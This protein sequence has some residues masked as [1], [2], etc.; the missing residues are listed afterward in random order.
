M[1][2]WRSWFALVFAGVAV[3][4]ACSG[5]TP[6]PAARGKGGGAGLAAAGTAGRGGS[7][8]SVGGSF[9]E[10]GE[11]GAPFTPGGGRAGAPATGGAGGELAFGGSGNVAGGGFPG[12]AGS[13]SAGSAGAPF[14]W[15]CALAAYGDGSCHCGCGAPDP[16]CRN[17]KLGSCEVCDAVGAC[18]RAECPGRIDADNTVQCRPVPGAWLCDYLTYED[19][20]SCDCGCGVPDPDCE[21]DD[22]DACD[23]CGRVGS[24]SLAATCPGGIDATDNSQCSYPRLWTCE[25]NVY[26]DGT[27]D[28]GCG[29]Q[30]VDCP[31]LSVDDCERCSFGC[32]FSSCPGNIYPDNNPFCTVVPAGWWCAPRFY[33]DGMVCHCGCGMIDPDCNPTEPDS[34]DR[35][36]AAGS[37]SAQ[38]CPGTISTVD[39]GA[40]MQ[41]EPPEEW[42]CEGSSYG[43]GVD[44]D[45]GCGVVDVDCR[46]ATPAACDRCGPC[47]ACPDRVDPTDISSCVPAPDGWTCAD[48]LYSDGAS[49]DCGCGVLDPDCFEN[50]R[51][52]CTICPEGSCSRSDC[53]DLDPEDITVCDGGIPMGWTCPG[54]Y[55]GDLGC[56]CG[57]GAQDEDCPTLSASVCEF[58]DSPG[59]CSEETPTCPG[60]IDPTNNAVCE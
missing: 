54:D 20:T 6:A 53:R 51:G 31:S 12:V 44:C 4:V 37:C 26:G 36:N 24:C 11:G 43:D 19:G 47:G 27:C 3:V 30:D 35:C 52:Y 59:S 15:T 21:E 57:C 29:A 60:D 32:S 58:C 48:E 38:D 45:C 2:S 9:T 8:A 56:D 55:Y 22:R 41:P 5:K 42:T 13:N 40:C 33:G 17:A 10:G 25:E 16:D 18:G 28:C 49:C 1:V 34:C 14:G 7:S 23:T 39:I 46:G 50:E